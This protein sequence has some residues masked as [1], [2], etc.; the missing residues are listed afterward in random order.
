[1]WIHEK[2]GS[3]DPI[4]PIMMERIG[5][6]AMEFL[7]VLAIIVINTE[8]IAEDIAPLVIIIIGV[9]S[10]NFFLFFCE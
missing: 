6:S 7:I 2:R 10:W 9:I 5:G 8:A 3:E 1:M 4:D